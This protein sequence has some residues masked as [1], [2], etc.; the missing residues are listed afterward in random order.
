[1][2]RAWPTRFMKEHADEVRPNGVVLKR[3]EVQSLLQQAAK[4]VGL[5]PDR[6]MSHSLRIGGATAL[7]QS[8]GEIELVKRQ[9]VQQC[10][11]P[12]PSRWG[13]SACSGVREDGAA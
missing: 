9:V 1:M 2:Q 13:R 8:T 4:A 5:P 12:V 10:R 6:F 7:F 11:S 3:T